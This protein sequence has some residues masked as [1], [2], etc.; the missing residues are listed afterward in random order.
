MALKQDQLSSR[1]AERLAAMAAEMREL[2]YG[3][4]GHPEWGTTFADIEADGKAIGLELARLTI[5]QSVASQ[6]KEVPPEAWEVPDQVIQPAGRKRRAV[7][8]ETGE[9]AWEEPQGYS[10][11]HRR[12]FSPSSQGPEDPC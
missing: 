9:V 12:A 2:L 7:Q 1:L 6:A 3:E 11:S 10:K 8:T 5:E 4:I